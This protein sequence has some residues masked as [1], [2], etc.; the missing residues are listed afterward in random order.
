MFRC[1]YRVS[2]VS[3]DRGCLW[4]KGQCL[5]GQIGS[6]IGNMFPMKVI[7]EKVKLTKKIFR[8]LFCRL[9][10][11]L[12]KICLKNKRIAHVLCVFVS[13]LCRIIRKDVT[14]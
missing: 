9:K 14:S 12:K 1:F 13:Y 11:V 6:G 10:V 2:F 8:L 7:E 3:I 4:L 5:T